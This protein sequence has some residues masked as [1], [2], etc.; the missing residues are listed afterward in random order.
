MGHRGG[1]PGRA[2]LGRWERARATGPVG[3]GDKGARTVMSLTRRCRTAVVVGVGVLSVWAP[4]AG[5]SDRVV[6]YALGGF[7]PAPVGPGVGG[8]ASFG[9]CTHDRHSNGTAWIGGDG[10][11]RTGGNEEAQCQGT[12]SQ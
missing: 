3:C 7:V 6:P 4:A 10:Q 8:S 11:A 2:I 5:A 1:G 12:G 9:S